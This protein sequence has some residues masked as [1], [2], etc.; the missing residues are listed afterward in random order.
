MTFEIER[1]RII[2]NIPELEGY[3]KM[4]IKQFYLFED[5]HKMLR[6]RQKWD[7]YYMTFKLEDGGRMGTFEFEPELTKE[8]FDAI[9]QMQTSNGEKTPY[10]SKTRYKIPYNNVIIE[11]DIFEWVHQGLAMAE[12]EFNSKEDRDSFVIP[13]WFAREVTDVIWFR[14]WYLATHGLE[15]VNEYL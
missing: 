5:E 11:L 8:Q 1:K 14:N 2:S 3:E 6:I 9:V 4:S 7:K 12:V 15:K 13:D 10:I